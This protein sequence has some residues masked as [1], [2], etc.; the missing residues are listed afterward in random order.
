MTPAPIDGP[1]TP[2]A[3]RTVRR[4]TGEHRQ[5]SIAHAKHLYLDKHLSIR[6]I[7]AQLHVGYGTVQR[8]L[9]EGNVT[10]RKRGGSRSRKHPTSG[11][12]ATP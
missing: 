2:P 9:R 1:H 7:A 3:K 5:R 11:H 6:A 10:L 12:S 8:F 4:I